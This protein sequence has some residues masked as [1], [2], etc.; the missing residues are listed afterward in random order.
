MRSR[1][2]ILAAIA[3]LVAIGTTPAFATSQLVV[4]QPAG[5]DTEVGDDDTGDV[6]EGETETGEDPAEDGSGGDDEISEGQ[7]DAEAETGS[8]E[9]ATDEA[10]AETGPPWTYQMARIIL[11]LLLLL[12]LS[13]GWMYWKL[14]ASRQ[15]GAA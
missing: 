8:G 2:A 6:E 10:E 5:D 11:A 15:K 12:A 14:I 13:I 3:L 1:W 9:E 7:S 4:A